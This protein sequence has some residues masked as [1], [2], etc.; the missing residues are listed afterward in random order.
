[1]QTIVALL[2]AMP[3]LFPGIAREAPRP[4][5]SARMRKVITVQPVKAAGVSVT[6]S[7]WYRLAVCESGMNGV[8]RW[9]YNGPSGYDGGL[10]FHPQTWRAY[11]LEGYPDYAYNASIEQQINV[12][13]RVLDSQGWKAWP[14]CSRK[15]GL[16]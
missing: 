3:V 11:K 8:P 10:Q 14:A 1:M 12:A 7:V 16:R 4:D 15:L 9:D 6:G 2:V 5:Q 13:E